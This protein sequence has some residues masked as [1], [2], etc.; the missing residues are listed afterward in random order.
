MSGRAEEEPGTSQAAG[1]EAH[2]EEAV[3]TTDSTTSSPPQRYF[4][5]DHVQGDTDENGDRDD[6]DHMFPITEV[7]PDDLRAFFEDEELYEVDDD[8]EDEDEDEDY[9]GNRT[10]TL[11]SAFLAV[12]SHSPQTSQM[13][14]RK[15]KRTMTMTV[16]MMD[17]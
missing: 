15:R 10:H 12:Y 17:S 8:D 6:L 16:W 7:N 5:A 1:P 4:D 11:C 9:E 14:R 13:R 2:V 3:R